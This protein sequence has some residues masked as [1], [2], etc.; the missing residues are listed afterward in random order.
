MNRTIPSIHGQASN[1]RYMYKHLKLY[2]LTFIIYVCLSLY[3]E[4]GCC[5]QKK[6]CSTHTV[7]LY[8]FLCVVIRNASHTVLKYSY[9]YVTHCFLLKRDQGGCNIESK[10]EKMLKCIIFLWVT[11][12]YDV[13]I[14]LIKKI[15]KV[16]LVKFENASIKGITFA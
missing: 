9:Y 16:F 8:Y 6:G 2:T 11:I 1:R 13:V 15:C 12:Q 10:I 14:I 7:L 4:N 3:L 5:T